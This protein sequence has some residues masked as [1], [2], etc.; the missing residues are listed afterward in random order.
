MA[1]NVLSDI[2]FVYSENTLKRNTEHMNIKLYD[3]HSN[4]WPLKL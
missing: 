4:H 3:A 1:V 2:M